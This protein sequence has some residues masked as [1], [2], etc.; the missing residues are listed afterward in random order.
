MFA[1][2]SR[3][4]PSGV[5]AVV[6]VQRAQPVEPDPCVDLARR[7]RRPPL[8]SVD[9]VAGGVEVARVEADAEPRM[10]VEP[11]EQ[12]LQLLERAADRAAGAGRVLHQQP[13]VAR[14]SARGSA[15]ARRHVRSSPTS[16]PAPRCEPTWKIT[17]S[18]SIAVAASIVAA[19]RLRSTSRRSR[20]RAPRGCRGRARGRRRR[21]S[22]PRPAAP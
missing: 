12:R 6:D 2:R 16:N 4:E 21:R 15:P 13:R 10:A 5:G 19:H 18:A 14:R 3:F 20:R 22:R 11:L 8:G 7:A 9:V 17:P 1:W